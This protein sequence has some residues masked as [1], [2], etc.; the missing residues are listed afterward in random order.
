MRDRVYHQYPP[1]I[2]VFV[3]AST[4]WS[5]CG[6]LEFLQCVLGCLASSRVVLAQLRKWSFLVE[7]DCL[8]AGTVLIVGGVWMGGGGGWGVG[9]ALGRGGVDVVCRGGRGGCSGDR[10]EGGAANDVELEVLCCMGL[11]CDMRTLRTEVYCAAIKY[12]LK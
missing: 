6:G 1:K 11:G 3:R 8:L 9:V 5:F 10:E 4:L 2:D 12:V 7:R